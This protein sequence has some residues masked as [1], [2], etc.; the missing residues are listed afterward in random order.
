MLSNTRPKLTVR[1]LRNAVVE[2]YRKAPRFSCHLGAIVKA[3][4]LRVLIVDQGLDLVF[5]KRVILV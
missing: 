3:L 5:T 4:E 1:A 2:N